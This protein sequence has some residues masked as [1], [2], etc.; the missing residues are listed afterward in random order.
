MKKTVL[1]LIICV[2]FLLLGFESNDSFSV[3]AF[4]NERQLI[5]NWKITE[6]IDKNVKI[7]INK[8]PA[9]ENKENIEFIDGSLKWEQYSF[10]K[11]RCFK[12]TVNGKYKM[13][14]DYNYQKKAMQTK[15]IIDGN[16]PRIS[17]YIVLALN[18]TL[19]KLQE[20]NYNTLKYYKK[21]K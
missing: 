8:I 5:G 12:S 3:Q 16:N 19:L 6:I 20:K 11:N 1:I 2:G 17:D 9:C 13:I 15:L 21:V 4:Y 18:D 14:V 7:D 10:R